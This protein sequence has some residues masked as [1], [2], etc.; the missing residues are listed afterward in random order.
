MRTLTEVHEN[1]VLIKTRVQIED[2]RV[3][4]LRIIL[5][6]DSKKIIGLR[7]GM[8]GYTIGARVFVCDSFIA[9]VCLKCL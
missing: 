9:S 6:A 8:G 5:F 2:G 1:S 7:G 4:D 3:Y